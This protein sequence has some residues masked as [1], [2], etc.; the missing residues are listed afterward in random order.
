MSPDRG[1]QIGASQPVSGKIHVARDRK[2]S[3]CLYTVKKYFDLK[4]RTDV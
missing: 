2:D 3:C 1:T 4:G